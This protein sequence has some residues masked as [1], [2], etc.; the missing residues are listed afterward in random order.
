IVRTSGKAKLRYQ[1]HRAVDGAYEVITATEVTPGDV[2]EAQ[3]M[4]W[5][6]DTHQLNTETNVETVVADSKY[7]T[8]SNY[9]DCYDRGIRAHIPDL[10][11]AQ[12]NSGFRGKIFSDEMFIYDGKT[13]TYTCPSGKGLRRKSLHMSR[14]SM[15]YAALGSDCRICSLR[16]HCTKNKA[17]RTVKRHLRQEEL[18]NM[19][20]LAGTALSKND[21]KTRQHLMERSFARAKRYGY[22]RARWRGLWRVRIQEYLT[23]AIQNIQILLKYGTDPR[24]AVGVAKVD[25]ELNGKITGVFKNINKSLLEFFLLFKSEV[26][27]YLVLKTS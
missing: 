4:L 13:D 21:I 1:T 14:R 9:L 6:I 12:S 26:E 11:E 25:G 18:D 17:G 16:P 3:K 19:R 15:D 5:L 22:D 27:P 20:A 23:A 8:I 24:I 7:G 2:N 10:K